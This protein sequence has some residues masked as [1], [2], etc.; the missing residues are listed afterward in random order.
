MKGILLWL[1]PACV[2]KCCLIGHKLSTV[3]S[4]CCLEVNHDHYMYIT[5]TVDYLNSVN[6]FLS[7]NSCLFTCPFTC[8]VRLLGLAQKCHY[9]RNYHGYF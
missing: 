5:V 7:R 2:M 1:S 3:V 8:L 4:H 6:V 9:M